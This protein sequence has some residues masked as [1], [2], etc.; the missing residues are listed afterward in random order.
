MQLLKVVKNHDGQPLYVVQFFATGT[1]GTTFSKEGSNVKTRTDISETG[2]AGANGW[3]R[4]GL[5]NNAQI[6]IMLNGNQKNSWENSLRAVI[7]S[8]KNTVPPSQS[9]ADLLGEGKKQDNL[10][11]KLCVVIAPKQ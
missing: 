9:A 4:R 10:L 2:V 7:T 11:I 8:T 1:G 6:W 5:Y 3:E